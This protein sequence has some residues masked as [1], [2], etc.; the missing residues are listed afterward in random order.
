M[1]VGALKV[2]GGE[3]CPSQW[4]AAERFLWLRVLYAK[5]KGKKRGKRT[6]VEIQKKLMIVAFGG[7]T[8]GTCYIT[9]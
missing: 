5:Q 6:V 8:C 4:K 7:L 9:N 2:E 3:T 1:R